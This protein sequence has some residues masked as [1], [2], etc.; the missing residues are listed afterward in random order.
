MPK[1]NSPVKRQ[2]AALLLLGMTLLGMILLALPSLAATP[3]W[4]RQAA[5]Q[6]LPTYD[7]ET[8]AVV[9]REDIA[10]TVTSPGEYVEHYRSAVKILR[11]EGRDEADF[12]IYLAGHEKLHSIHCLTLDLTGRE[13]ELKEK[14]FAELGAVSGFELYSDVRYRAGVCPA[15]DP[16][17]I[18]AFEYEV[19]RRGWVNEVGAVLQ[20]SIPVHETHVVLNLPLGWEFR[21][22]WANG[23]PVQP[24]K[25]A[26]GS[27]EWILRD[28]PALA[29]EPWQPPYRA[30]SLTMGL[31]YFA[32]SPGFLDAGSWEG[33]GRWY[34]QLTADR[35]SATPDLTEKA[36][37]LTAGKADF[38]G[39]VH[40]LASFLQ[41]DV[42]Y[43][44]IS[45]GIGGFQ[46]HPAAETF[47]ARYGDCKDKATLLSAMLHEVGIA[48]DYVLINTHR[49]IVNSSIPS[50]VFDHAILAIEL[51]ADVKNDAYRSSLTAKSGKRYLIFDPTDPFTPLG[52]LRGDLQDTNALLV[53]G[54]TGELIHTP[55]FQPEA[56]QLSRT[57][58]FTVSAD[59][60]LSGEIVESRSG[61]HAVHER[62]FLLSATQQQRSQQL[63]QFLSRSLKGF[64]LESSDVQQLEQLQQN[65]A[66]TFKF[67]DP[68]YGQIRGPL[69]LL[70]PRIIGEKGVPLEHKPRHFPYQFEDTSRE[71]DTYEFDLPS[72]YVVDDVP[73]PVNVDMGFAAYHSKIEV[74][75]A[76]LRYS[77]E[78]VRRDVL[79][80]SNRT[81]DLHKLQ[82]IIGADE[83]NAVVLKRAQ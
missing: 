26:D 55:L 46:P 81:D 11:P 8:N 30:L 60:V 76:R 4:V 53:A 1:Q 7:P 10:F 19:Q 22:V 45:I 25:I 68:G 3:D 56:N 40:A 13:Y 69:M 58:H 44:E 34:T 14:D 43:V 36:R 29:R 37:Q 6:T 48:S 17:S 12:G 78:F 28:L 41:S 49:G 18:V 82:G 70:R 16:G 66:I 50:L 9:L 38:D 71:T 63:E 42:R 74:M 20:K 72:N 67:T 61:D 62:Q 31:V 80:P 77:R 73:A 52:D 2:A 32:P 35:R 21:S 75:G 59:G 27:W 65:L 54:G 39:R 15:A 57:G 83:N 47:R 33:L 23:E 79:I 51:P 5:A 64:T 24:K